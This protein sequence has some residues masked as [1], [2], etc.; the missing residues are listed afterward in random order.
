MISLFSECYEV[1]ARYMLWHSWAVRK[2][3]IF[4][5]IYAAW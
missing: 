1:V 2:R 4:W 3:G 5:R